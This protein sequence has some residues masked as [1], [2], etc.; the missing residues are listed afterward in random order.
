[1]K[2]ALKIT[3]KSA[4]FYRLLLGEVCPE[5]SREIGQFFRKFV[6]KNLAE[7]GFFLLRPIRS[8]ALSVSTYQ[9]SQQYLAECRMV[10]T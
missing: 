5:N 1:M 10:V 6:P 9:H 4:V 3:T 2:F 7:F 8:P